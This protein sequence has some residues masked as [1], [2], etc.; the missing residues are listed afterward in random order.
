MQTPESLRR[1]IKSATDLLGVVK[2]MKTLAAVN[3]RH[4]ERAV[5]SLAEYNRTVEMGLHIVLSDRN[6]RSV[7]A[8]KQPNPALG[9]IVFGSD[10]GL[11]GAYNERIATIAAAQIDRLHRNHV[12]PTVAAVGVRVAVLL[13]EAGLAV[14]QVSGNTCRPRWRHPLVQELLIVIERWR[15]ERHTDEIVLFHNRP[16]GGAAYVPV[17]SRLLPLDLEWL[18][19]LEKTA[20]P[21][22]VLPTFTM[23]WD[24]LFAALVRQYLFVTLYRGSA[25]ALASENASRLGSMQNAER[26]IEDRLVE[27]NR[28]YHTCAKT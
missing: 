17:F 22:H 23:P 19:T 5:A 11:C 27:L 24:Q 21:S 3:I 25:E 13:E 12:A 15:L 20:W 2:T 9:A 16:A 1:Q 6:G 14:R 4:Y 26:N 18:S 8:E 10:Q 28:H 7:V